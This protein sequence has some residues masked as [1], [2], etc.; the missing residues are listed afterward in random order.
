MSASIKFRNHRLV[1]HAFTPAKW[2]GGRIT[3]DLIVLHD[4]AG[5]LDHGNSAT[6][7]ANNP[8]K[9]SVHFV[10][11]R[12]GT[13]TQQVATNR[14]ANHAGNS[15][16]HGRDGCNDFSIG[17]EIVSVGRLTFADDGR[18]R[19]W[20]KKKYD[21]SGSNESSEIH[22]LTTP[23]HG[24]GLWMDYTSEQI[25]ACVLLCQA[26]FSYI[27]SIKDIRGHWYVSPGRKVDPNP[28]FPM[29]ALRSH[30]MGRRDLSP[31]TDLYA[32]EPGGNLVAIETP[33]DTLNMRRWPSY[34]PNIIVGI[35]D[36]TVVPVIRRGDFGGEAW[37]LVRYAGQEGWVN[38]RYTANIT[39]AGVPT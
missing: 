14:R 5:R 34:N 37:E 10:I 21:I 25:D 23:E 38:S 7:L 8:A 6:Y 3:P 13:I 26:L 24:S 29:E 4:T 36:G 35:P 39:Y 15:T 18:A 16:Y 27:P 1:N 19:T 28:L 17:I 31:S 22:N 12:D 9:V 2:V 33:G 11:E 20:F 32:D 30:V